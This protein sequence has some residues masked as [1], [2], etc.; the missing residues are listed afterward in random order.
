[1]T[2]LCLREVKKHFGATRALDGVDF[3]LERGEVHGLIGENG[4]GKS[5]LMNVIAGELPPDSGS[6][7]LSERPFRPVSTLDARLR[8]I[9]LIHQELMLAPHLSVAENL[10]M[11]M[12]NSRFG[13]L[14]R[15]DLNK[16][17]AD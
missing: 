17:A 14:A 7:E 11:G 1:M 15:N 13:W 2:I 6:M 8:G 16:R 12:E 4:A 9:A 3:S 5:T 10:L